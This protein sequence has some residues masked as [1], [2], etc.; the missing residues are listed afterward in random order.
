MDSSVLFS[1]FFLTLLLGVGLFFFIRAATKDR[2][3][4]VTLSSTQSSE[5]LLSMLQQYFADRAYHVEQVDPQENRVRLSG[6]VRPSLFLAVFLSL[7]AG[8]GALCLGLVFTMALPDYPYLW[9]IFIVFAPLAG[10]FYWQKASR[11]EQVSFVLDAANQPATG[12][13]LRVSAHRDELAELK[14]SLN[15]TIQED[16]VRS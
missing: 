13:T 3:Q 8:I 12:S 16:A 11:T 1:T 14:R 10:R 6:Q 7:L 9:T 2:T 4:I 5:Q 15:L